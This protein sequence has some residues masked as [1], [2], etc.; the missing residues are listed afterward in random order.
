MEISIGNSHNSMDGK[1]YCR[2][3]TIQDARKGVLIEVDVS[4]LDLEQ[5]Q[6]EIDAAVGYAEREER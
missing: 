5:W 1:S 3:V 2:T 4:T 6:E